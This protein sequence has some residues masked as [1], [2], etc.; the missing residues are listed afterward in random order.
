MIGD[1]PYLDPHVASAYAR[2]A[3][4]SQFVLP[5]RDLVGLLYVPIGATVLDVGSGTGVVAAALARAVG[6]AGRVIAADPS[7]AMLSA[8]R[9]QSPVHAVVARMP[10][11]PFPKAAFDAVTASFVISHLVS[12]A[13]GLADMSRICKPGGH[14]GVTAWGTLPNPAG[15]LWKQVAMTTEGGEPLSEAFRSA[16]P[17]DEWLS[18]TDNLEH[19]L[20]E[21]RLTDVAVVRRDFVVS[22]SAA[23]Y[24]AMKG[25]TVEGTLLRRILTIERWHQFTHEVTEAFRTGFGD[26]VEFTRDFLIGTGTK[27]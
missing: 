26:V 16:I 7:A 18:H 5:A 22:V 12:Y 1:S 19:A 9:P 17:W 4:P 25:A 27:A 21:A 6:A 13:D 2:L 15:G 11:L 20:R 10:G 14:V 24:V 3:A 23:D 8:V